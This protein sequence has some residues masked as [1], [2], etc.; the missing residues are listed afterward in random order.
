MCKSYKD[1]RLRLGSD[2]PSQPPEP[3]SACAQAYRPHK[4]ETEHNTKI[5]TVINLFDLILRITFFTVNL[6][7]PVGIWLVCTCPGH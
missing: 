2:G 6:F 4:S 5:N 1:D 7:F 3:L